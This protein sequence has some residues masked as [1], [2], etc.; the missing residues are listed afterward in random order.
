MIQE[1]QNY[2]EQLIGFVASFEDEL[3]NQVLYKSANNQAFFDDFFATFTQL[4]QGFESL[5]QVA[6]QGNPLLQTL[7]QKLGQFNQQK[8]A[9]KEEFAEIERKLAGELKPGWIDTGISNA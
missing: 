6:T 8:Q 1:T 4:L 5:K 9:L 3:K 2:L 7:Q